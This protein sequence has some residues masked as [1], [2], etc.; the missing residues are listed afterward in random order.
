MV[1]P[2][3]AP[4]TKMVQ[5]REVIT[6]ML[7]TRPDLLVAMA[8][9]GTRIFINPAVDGYAQQ[10]PDVFEAYVPVEDLYCFTLIH[11]FS[12][13]IH[14]TLGEIFRRKSV[15]LAAPGFV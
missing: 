5:T 7:S 15:Q 8:D 14:Y 12:H 9:Y 6:S 2:S 11:E 4:D 10:L 1:A 13:V 3:A